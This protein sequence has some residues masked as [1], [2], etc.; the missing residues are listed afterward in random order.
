MRWFDSAGGLLFCNI[1]IAFS[2]VMLVLGMKLAHSLCKLSS[3]HEIGRYF[4]D[5][6]LTKWAILV[7]TSMAAYLLLSWTD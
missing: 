6:L 3:F 4:L 1:E 5:Q 2:V 7:L